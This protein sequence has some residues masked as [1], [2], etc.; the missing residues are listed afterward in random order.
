MGKHYYQLYLAIIPLVNLVSEPI[1]KIV[2][3]ASWDRVAVVASSDM[4]L[5]LRTRAMLLL[6]DYV[7]F[8]ERHQLQSLLASADS[9]L[10]GL[11]RFAH[12]TCEGPLVQLSLAIL[13][14]VCLHSPAEDISLIPQEVW[15]NIETLG[16]SSTG[17]IHLIGCQ[18]YLVFTGP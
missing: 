6:V 1:L 12:V 14:S 16:M 10:Y 17:T 13:A 4:S 15:K 18:Q 11:G 2:V 5:L 3:S 9:V 8:S 7:P